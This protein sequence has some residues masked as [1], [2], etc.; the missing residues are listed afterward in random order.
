MNSK[1]KETYS[2]QIVIPGIGEEGQEKIKKSKILIIGAGGLGSPA[3]LYLSAAGV[4]TIGIMD[5]DNVELSNLQRQIIHSTHELNTPKVTSAAIKMKDRNPSMEIII[6]NELLTESNADKIISDYD[7]IIDATDN[8]AAKYLINDVCV[9]LKKSYSHGAV[10]RFGGEAFTYIPG[11][12]CYRC[13]FGEAPSSSS[14]MTNKE[15]GVMGSVVGIIGTI[16]ATEAIKY[17]CGI[18]ELLTDKLLV[19]DA[20]NMNF[21]KIRF[22]NVRCGRCN[23]G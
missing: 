7:F 12:A 11:H 23:K 18:G 8:F 1:E 5:N 3:A 10:I 20:L 19:V 15:A 13:I 16:Q 17:I 21:N 2:R 6:Y 9:N 22:G 14:M 4:G